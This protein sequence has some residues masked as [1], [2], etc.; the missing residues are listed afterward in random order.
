MYFLMRRRSTTS[1]GRY[2]IHPHCGLI[3]I[4]V[5]GILFLLSSNIIWF[6]TPWVVGGTPDNTLHVRQASNA[7]TNIYGNFLSPGQSRQISPTTLDDETRAG[8][9]E[10]VEGR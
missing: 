9:E 1:S 10:D 3:P 7:K 4:S 6:G 2:S 8:I 5:F